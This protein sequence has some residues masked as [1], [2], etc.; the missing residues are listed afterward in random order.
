MTEK[1]SADDVKF[2]QFEYFLTKKQTALIKEANEDT[3]V[4]KKKDEFQEGP[5]KIP[6]LEN[7]QTVVSYDN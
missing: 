3:V 4:V 2:D 1:I 5:I 7:Y 6:E